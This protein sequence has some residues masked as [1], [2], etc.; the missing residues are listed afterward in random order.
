MP[1]D[2]RYMHTIDRQPAF[3]D[4]NQIVF[5]SGVVKQ[6]ASTIRQIRREQRATRRWR[7]DQGYSLEVGQLGYVRVE[8]PHAD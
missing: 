2:T 6:T 1:T 7:R 8:M 5:A 3:Y 4:G